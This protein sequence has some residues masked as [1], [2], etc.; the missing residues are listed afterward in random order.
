MVIVPFSS[1][2]CSC[3]HVC[4]SWVASGASCRWLETDRGGNKALV[5]I[6]SSQLKWLKPGEGTQH[7]ASHKGCWN[8]W[9]LCLWGAASPLHA[10]TTSNN[11][12]I[13]STNITALLLTQLLC[14]CLWRLIPPLQAASG[15]LLP[16]LDGIL[17]QHE[18]STSHMAPFQRTQT[19]AAAAG[20]SRFPLPG[21]NQ[22]SVQAGWSCCWCRNNGVLEHPRRRLC[23]IKRC[24]TA[25]GTPPQ[26]HVGRRPMEFSWGQVSAPSKTGQ[27]GSKSAVRGTS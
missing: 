13:T 23:E 12:I 6:P 27:L 17:S 11:A 14:C 8:Y 3:N 15:Y 19:R 21:S 7:A 16:F 24:T 4:D 22:A 10:Y 1:P 18:G 9:P 20:L 25:S 2:P 5:H 26:V